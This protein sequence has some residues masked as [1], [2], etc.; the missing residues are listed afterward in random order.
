MSSGSISED[1]KTLSFELNLNGVCAHFVIAH[2]DANDEHNMPSKICV[3]LT[4]RTARLG[5]SI[6]STNQ[7]I[8]D[9]SHA[10]VL[11]HWFK[12]TSEVMDEWFEEMDE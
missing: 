1:R 10:K 9:K 2:V 4:T 7:I 8:I 6:T 5:A 11:S 12:H 3:S